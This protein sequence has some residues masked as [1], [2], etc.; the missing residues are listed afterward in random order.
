[1]K[2]TKVIIALISLVV[3]IAGLLWMIRR[4]TLP[5]PES[6]TV[7]VTM[8]KTPVTNAQ[9][10]AQDGAQFPF[11]ER[12]GIA[13]VPPRYLGQLIVVR[14]GQSLKELSR[15]ILKGGLNEIAL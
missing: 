14:D 2:D 7:V 3:A 5:Q 13:H 4:D 8:D 6:P 1:M 12:T 9:L 11:A 15:F 10:I